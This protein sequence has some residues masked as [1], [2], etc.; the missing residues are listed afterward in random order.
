MRREIWGADRA[1]LIRNDC[2]ASVLVN[3]ERRVLLIYFYFLLF[4]C[5][6]IT[7]VS[8]EIYPIACA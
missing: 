6:Y 4:S 1:G 8:T 3:G 5:Y 2:F 7:F